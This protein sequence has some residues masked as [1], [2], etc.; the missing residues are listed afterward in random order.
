MRHKHKSKSKVKNSV[1]VLRLRPTS[2]KKKNY[3]R[4]YERGCAY[5]TVRGTAQCDEDVWRWR[6]SEPSRIEA[7]EGRIDTSPASRLP[8]HM[9]PLAP[10]V[11]SWDGTYGGATAFL[12]TGRGRRVRHHHMHRAHGAKAGLMLQ[13]VGTVGVPI[14]VAVAIA[15]ALRARN[16][17]VRI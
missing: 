17:M 13:G 3:V 2:D 8:E 6:G 11:R 14:A 12:C 4:A 16:T 7:E 10:R 15:G 5:E 9:I 1:P